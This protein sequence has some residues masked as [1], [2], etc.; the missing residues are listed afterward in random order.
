[1]ASTCVPSGNCDTVVTGWLSSTHPKMTDGI[2][3]GKVCFSWKSHCCQWSQDI[4]LRDC[5]RFYVYKLGSTGECPMGFCGST[6]S[7][8]LFS[9]INYYS[10]FIYSSIK[11]YGLS[12][13]DLPALC[14]VEKL[15]TSGGGV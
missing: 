13:H 2:V 11:V 14:H 7:G 10:Y 3:S 4:K 8:M 12:C 9:Y 1:M 6:P 5:G 15:W